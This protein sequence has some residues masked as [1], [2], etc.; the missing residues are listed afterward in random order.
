MDLLDASEDLNNGTLEGLRVT[1]PNF[2]I[3]KSNEYLNWVD[4]FTTKFNR[5]PRYTDAYAYD[6]A[7][8]I[9][10]AAKYLTKTIGYTN[11][12]SKIIDA[13]M[14]TDFKGITGHIKF[15]DNRDLILDL[16]TC[17]YR[18]GHLIPDNN[19]L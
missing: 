11:D 13:L 17:F 9:N 4:K 8:I 15:K 5:K 7:F 6:M 10:N 16:K 1:V 3:T 14:K 12:N 18:D 2:L 19:S